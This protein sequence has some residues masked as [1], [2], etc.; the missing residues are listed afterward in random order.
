MI[1]LDTIWI[2]GCAGLVLL[3]QPGFMCLESGLTRSK[4]SINV[5]VKNLVDLGISICFFWAFGYA[6]MFGASAAGLIGTSNFFLNLEE[7]TYLAA[8]FIFQMMFCGTATTIVSGAL[9]ER[10]KFEGYLIIAMLISGIVYPI[11]GHWVWNGSDVDVLAGWLGQLGF[12]DFAGSS[13]VHC[14]GGWVSLAALLVVGPRIGRFT[15][16]QNRIHASNLPFSVLGVMLLWVGWLGFNGGSTFGLTEQIPAIMVHTVMAGAGGMIAA[17]ALGWYQKRILEAE[18]LINGSLAG[19]VSITAP[20][21]VVT[22][23][24][25]VLIGA[26]GGIVML[27]AVHLIEKSGIDDGVD[28]VAIH[29]CAGAWGVL[30]VGLFGDLEAIGTGI[31]RY[32]QLLVQLLGIG[33][34]FLWSFGLTYL[35][36]QTLN[37]HFPLRVSAEDEEIGLNV[38]EH[39]AKTEVYDLFQIMDQQAKTQDFSLRV[40]ESPFTEAGKIAHHY[41]KVM[42]SLE[43]SALQLKEMN[44]SLERKV[45]ERTQALRST[46]AELQAANRK[47]KRVDKLKDEFLANTSH[48]LRTPL[49]GIIGLSEYLISNNSEPLPEHATVNLDMIAR[50]GRRLYNLISDILDFSNLLQDNLRLD[51]KSVGLKEVVEVVLAL[52]KPLVDGKNL[53]L[54]NQVPA[55][56]SLLWTDEDRLQQILYN[57]VGNAV[58]FTNQGEVTISAEEKASTKAL[59]TVSDTGIGISP[60]KHNTIFESFEQAEGTTDRIYGG[61]GLGLAVTKKLVELQGGRIW[62]E[63]QL[64]RGSQ[65]H[66]ELPLKKSVVGSGST[67]ELANQV[68]KPVFSEK[69]TAAQ[70]SALGWKLGATEKLLLEKETPTYTDKIVRSNASEK[71]QEENLQEEGLRK[72]EEFEILIVDDDPVNLQVLDNYLGLRHYR[73]QR[74]NS[75][76]NALDLLETGYHPD[77]V[78]LDVMMPRMTGYE[79]TRVIR[80]KWERHELPIVLLTARNQLE[81]EVVGLAAGANDYLTKP[82]IKEGLLARIETQLSLRQESKDRQQAEAERI[83]FAQELE[84]TNL[85]L[86]LAQEELAQQNKTLEQQVK[87]RTAV[88]A[89]SERKLSTLMKNLPGMAYRAHNN[90]NCTMVFVSDGCSAL[91]GYSAETLTGENPVHFGQLIHPDDEMLV[92]EQV[93]ASIQLRCPFQLTYRIVL[94]KLNRIKWVWEQGQ[95]VFDDEGRPSFLEGFITDISDRIHSEQALEKTNQELHNLVAEIQSTQAELEIAKEKAEKASRAK[96]AFLANMSH[97]LRTPLNSIIGFAEMLNRDNSLREGHKERLHIIRRNGEHLL[98]MINNILDSSKLEAKKITLNRTTFD[99]YS[100]LDDVLNMFALKVKQKDIQLQLE[101]DDSLPQFATADAGKLRQI[102]V[103]LVG[104]G[105]KFTNKGSVRLKVKCLPSAA[106]TTS[107]NTSSSETSLAACKT[108]EAE[109]TKVKRRRIEADSTKKEETF[110]Q[111]IHFAVQDTGVGIAATDFDYLFTPFEQA[112]AGRAIRQGTGLGLSISQQ[113]CQLM[114]GQ[115]SV[116]STLGEGSTFEFQIPMQQVTDQQIKQ[117]KPTR[118]NWQQ[119]KTEKKESVVLLSDLLSVMSTDWIAELHQ[120]ASQLKSKQVLALIERIPTREEKLRACLVDIVNSYQFDQI[121]SVLGD[122]ADG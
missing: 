68:A 2:V 66:F 49:N 117:Y 44:T 103:N 111:T 93:E 14:V 114:G 33:V 64:K 12:V 29:G 11:F 1:D 112:E 58:K 19:L 118:S 105:V 13:V 62:V 67:D 74:A 34:A 50:S 80:S 90:R 42:S 8:F 75:G 5:A 78:I 86:L 120:A 53:Q 94:P 110:T 46:N 28:A 107:D 17:G 84:E 15:N 16:Q 92:W 85:A 30:S 20:C 70:A 71:L 35:V 115:I 116:T 27:L 31:G 4:N 25:A 87:K 65:F 39:Q 83:Q 73:V 22:T 106:L 21:N 104:N 52:C 26:T 77:L 24:L 108:E 122:S 89:E 47:L 81:D 6:L 51:P 54:V 37:R 38:S 91:T 97:E 69:T 56:F 43:T 60:E 40:P 3:M 57:L 63:S 96:S 9:A 41:N 88:L 121:T 109:A 76:Q 61:L 98:S 82:I 59:I 113:Y 102:L 23:P 10:L 101:R 45:A 100:L 119:P 79:V 36:L 32:H 55:D 95:A 99:L 18:T 7:D 72:E 48:E